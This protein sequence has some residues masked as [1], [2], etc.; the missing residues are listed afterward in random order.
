[1]YLL[2][3][4][5]LKL[6]NPKQS[7]K[8]YDDWL[9]EA[10]AHNFYPAIQKRRPSAYQRTKQRKA[11][12]KSELRKQLE[13]DRQTGFLCEHDVY[14]YGCIKCHPELIHLEPDINL[15]EIPF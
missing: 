10:V 7:G 2:N 4:R 13:H 8:Q 6:Q 11:R 15:D 5:F 3:R 1:M 12:E 14:S 9:K